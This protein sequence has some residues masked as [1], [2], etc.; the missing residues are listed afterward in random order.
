M[1]LELLP[2]LRASLIR[3]E[4]SRPKK[5]S[6]ETPKNSDA[7]F[8]ILHLQRVSS[9]FGLENWKHTGSFC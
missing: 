6:Y 9:S 8:S 1:E 4:P 2:M 5:E 3:K 7:H